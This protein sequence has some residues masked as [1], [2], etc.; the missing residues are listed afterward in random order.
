MNKYRNHVFVIPED[1]A[2]RQMAN[3]FVDHHAVA[4]T[5]IQVMPSAGGWPAV[6]E[7]FER[8]YVARL[9]NWPATHVV[10]LIDFDEGVEPRRE[11]FARA[12]PEEFRDRVFV[13]GTSDEPETLRTSVGRTFEE[14]GKALAAEC[15]EDQSA[16]WQHEQLSHND[17]ERERLAEVVKPFLFGG[18]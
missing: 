9:R 2:N 4:T 10:L 1:D 3:G 6:L 16:L 15:D 17:A 8:E 13:I 12:I 5:A 14:I 18:G 7:T 11:R